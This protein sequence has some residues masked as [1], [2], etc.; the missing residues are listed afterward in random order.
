MKSR[1]MLRKEPVRRLLSALR[2]MRS[3]LGLTR[4]TNYLGAGVASD[5]SLR[6]KIVKY[7]GYR[8]GRARTIS[9]KQ[10]TASIYLPVSNPK[11]PSS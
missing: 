8:T 5:K 4:S 11:V 9:Y 6:L 3:Q 10:R 1:Q 2:K 7:C